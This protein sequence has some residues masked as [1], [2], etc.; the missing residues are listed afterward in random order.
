MHILDGA[1]LIHTTQG[2][3]LRSLEV[4]GASFK[5]PRIVVM[6]RECHVVVL[7]DQS[8]LCLFT[9][10]GRLLKTA[11]ADMAIQVGINLQLDRNE[12]W[13]LCPRVSLVP[14]SIA[15]WRISDCWRWW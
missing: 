7:Y 2:E 4:P 3:L 5:C 1:V 14:L 6:S 11:K 15:R 8:D 13:S 9:T 12:Q 10:S